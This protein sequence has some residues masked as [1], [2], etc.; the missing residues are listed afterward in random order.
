MANEANSQPDIGPSLETFGP[1]HDQLLVLIEVECVEH[2]G[3][4]E[5][6]RLRA[7]PARRPSAAG[8]VWKDEYSTRLVDGTVLS[9]HDDWDCLDDLVRAGLVTLKEL[10]PG[11]AFGLTDAGWSRAHALRRARAKRGAS[12]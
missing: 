1:N 12:R 2:R 8:A 4:L 10:S 11:R 6:H 3:L 7:N 5:P 9:G